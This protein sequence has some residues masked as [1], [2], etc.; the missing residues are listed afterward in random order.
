MAVD[1]PELCQRFLHGHKQVLVDH[2]FEFFTTNEETWM[3]DPDTIVSICASPDL[4]TIYG[5]VRFERKKRT[6][7]LPLEKVIFPLD[8]SVRK[9]TNEDYTEGTGEMCGLWHSREVAGKNTTILMVRYAMSLLYKLNYT[10]LFVFT[11][12]YTKKIPLNLGFHRITTI[13][14]DGFFSYPTERFK[15]C[16]WKHLIGKSR[17]SFKPY[18]LEKFEKLIENPNQTIMEEDIYNVLIEYK[19]RI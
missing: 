4:T 11:A 7:L 14:D 17:E 8:L 19:M 18:D 2:G 12:E 6:F 10:S 13:G 15:A 9:I 16:V 1:E 5:G 3:F